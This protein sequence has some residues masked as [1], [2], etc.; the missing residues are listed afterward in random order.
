MAKLNPQLL[1]L[2]FEELVKYSKPYLK[3]PII[4]KSVIRTGLCCCALCSSICLA[5]N[6]CSIINKTHEGHIM[7]TDNCFDNPEDLIVKTRTQKHC[8]H[9]PFISQ[10]N[11]SSFKANLFS[12]VRRFEAHHGLVIET[13]ANNF[14][15]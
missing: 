9:N 8:H 1:P 2:N 6:H 13:K 14:G 15:W 5:K 12:N 11:S 10:K 4:I 7:K 3:S